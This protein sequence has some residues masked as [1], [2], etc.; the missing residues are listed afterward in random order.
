MM[1]KSQTEHS[2]YL[3]F[4]TSLPQHLVTDLCNIPM[5]P[6]QGNGCSRWCSLQYWFYIMWLWCYVD[7]DNIA[8]NHFS[9]ARIS[10]FYSS[11]FLVYIIPAPLFWQFVMF[12]LVYTCTVCTAAVHRTW[13]EW[14][15]RL[16]SSVGWDTWSW[17]GVTSQFPRSS[18]NNSNELT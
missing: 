13:V 7:T 18:M 15:S 5:S 8:P 14:V 10:F 9:L 6:L 12:S 17:M 2:G 1:I 3:L 4:T 11:T 16:I